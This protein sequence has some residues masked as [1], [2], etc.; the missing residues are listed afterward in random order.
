[1]QDFSHVKLSSNGVLK[2]KCIIFK[3]LKSYKNSW[4]TARSKVDRLKLNCTVIWAKKNSPGQFHPFGAFSFRPLNCQLTFLETV[5]FHPFR[6]TSFC[7]SDRPLLDFR[8]VHFRRPSTFSL[9]D[10]SVLFMTSFFYSC[11]VSV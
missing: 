4:L 2:F 11:W 10:R 9:L 1:M 8:T 3:V 6:S 5:Q 7:L